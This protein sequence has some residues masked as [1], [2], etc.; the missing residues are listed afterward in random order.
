MELQSTP[1]N[2]NLQGKQK[3]KFEFSG[4]WV[5]GVKLRR[6]QPEGK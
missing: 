3:K 6:K 2:S 4:V 1:N 5:I